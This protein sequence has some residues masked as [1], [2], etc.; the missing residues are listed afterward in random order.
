M[1]ASDVF[2]SATH[3]SSPVRRTDSS[4]N[5]SSFVAD[6]S[7]PPRRPCL[8]TTLS[9]LVTSTCSLLFTASSSLFTIASWSFLTA[10][11]SSLLATTQPSLLAHLLIAIA[12]C[13]CV[14]ARHRR[15]F[16]LGSSS[17]C[18]ADVFFIFSSSI[19]SPTHR[20]RTLPTKAKAF[21]T[22]PKSPQGG[23][24]SLVEIQEGG[25]D[26]V[27]EKDD[28][29]VAHDSCGDSRWANVE[30]DPMIAVMKELGIKRLRFRS[31]RWSFR[32]ALMAWKE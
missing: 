20:N 15:L 21:F 17:A 12:H 10:A 8:T 29:V 26:G 4:P 24:A 22:P 11:L 1:V 31:P 2:V 13:R 28:V 25:C 19:S 14:A 18:S 30:R 7:L 16:S 5:P 23:K 27:V 9:Q 6:Y 32:E 3:K